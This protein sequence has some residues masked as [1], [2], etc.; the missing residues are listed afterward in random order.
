MKR[1]DLITKEKKR[2]KREERR[3]FLKKA[4]YSAP[5]LVALGTLVRPEKGH[6]DFGGPPSDPNGS[7]E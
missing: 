4:V 3:T 6:A 2:E 7:T 1:K 5:T